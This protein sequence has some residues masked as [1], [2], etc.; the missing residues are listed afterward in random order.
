MRWRDL[1]RKHNW[2]AK[3]GSSNAT[4]SRKGLVKMGLIEELPDLDKGGKPT[5]AHTGLYRIAR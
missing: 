4:R 3:W 1:A 2:A 5:G